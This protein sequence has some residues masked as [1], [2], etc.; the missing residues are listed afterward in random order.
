MFVDF[1][2]VDTCYVVCGYTDLRKGIDGL[3]AS[4]SGKL[5][6]NLFESS[7]FLFCGRRPDRFKA[8][9][10]DGEGFYLLYKRY[11]QGRLEWPRST[12]E[13]Q[14]LSPQQIE[15]LFH[16]FSIYQK[17]RPAKIGILT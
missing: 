2:R 6:L 13:A 11:D 7:V 12:E 3:S 14:K 1:S 9:W 10:F 15:W 5:A 8:L 4:V 17:I 16:G